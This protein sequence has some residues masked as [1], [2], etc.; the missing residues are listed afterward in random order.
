MKRCVACLLLI[1]FSTTLAAAQTPEQSTGQPPTFLEGVKVTIQ[2]YLG[3]RYVWGA[4]GIKSFDCSGSI[5]RV[6]YE[7]GVLLK[8]TTARKLYMMLPAVPKEEQWNF[9]TLIFF[10]D[11]THVGI[12]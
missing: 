5:W 2:K 9:G 11:L 10:D 6:M 8:R 1:V 7:N 3:R 12:V 4:T